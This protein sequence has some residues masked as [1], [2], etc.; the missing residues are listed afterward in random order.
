ML[1]QKHSKD[2]LA[3]A[4]FKCKNMIAQVQMKKSFLK[5]V[6]L[7]CVYISTLL[8]YLSSAVT[9]PLASQILLLATCNNMWTC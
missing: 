6:A 5:K 4:W 8:K 2:I 9:N 3:T 7:L 1:W